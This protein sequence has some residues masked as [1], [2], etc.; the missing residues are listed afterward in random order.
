[1]MLTLRAPV[2]LNM[3]LL[4]ANRKKWQAVDQKKELKAIA[5]Q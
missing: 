2:S 4:V 5:F 3:L 1:M